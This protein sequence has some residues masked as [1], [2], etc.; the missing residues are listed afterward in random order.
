MSF[1]SLCPRVVAGH[2]D[3]L[4]RSHPSDT[5]STEALISGL[6]GDDGASPT[7]GS[8]CSD[9]ESV[10]QEPPLCG[11]DVVGVDVEIGFLVVALCNSSLKLRDR[12]REFDI[13]EFE[14][15]RLSSID[16]GSV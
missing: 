16:V 12:E 13:D 10:T 14:E 9:N 5:G 2:E 11:R 7:G 6:D 1:A 15:L 4:P 8:F 3:A